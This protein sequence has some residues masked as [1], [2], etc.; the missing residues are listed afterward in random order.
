MDVMDVM[1]GPLTYPG[2]IITN[3]SAV[4]F[5]LDQGGTRTLSQEVVFGHIEHLG[6]VGTK[7]RERDTT[8][9]CGCEGLKSANL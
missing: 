8:R 5:D 1:E 2:S 7:L 6:K 4:R 3:I 9:E